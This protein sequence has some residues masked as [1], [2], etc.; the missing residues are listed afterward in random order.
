MQHAHRAAARGGRRRTW[1]AEGA[2]C[3]GRSPPASPPSAAGQEPLEA[4]QWDL[5]RD[6]RGQGA[7]EVAGQ[8]QGDGRRDRHRR[9]RHAPRPRAELRPSARRSTVSAGKPDTTDGRVARRARR[10]T[11]TARTWPVRSRRR[12]N[13]VGV[14]GVAP[15]VKVAG[16]K[17]S[18]TAGYF[19]TE[20]V[21]CGFVCA[22]DARRGDHE[23]QL[24][25]RPL[26]LTTARTTR[27]R[28]RS[29]TRS[30][31]RAVRGE[32][33]HGQ[34]RGGRQ[35]QLRPGGRRDHRPVLAERRH[36]SERVVD[37]SKCL[38]I[39]TQLPGVV[40]VAATGAKGIKSS[41]S[42]HGLGFIDVA[43]PGGDSTTYQKPRRPRRTAGSWARCPAASGATWPVRR[44]RAR[45]WR[46]SPR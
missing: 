34:R 5:A 1:G 14:P 30:R 7:R 32:E 17:V 38:D 18:T 4:E 35:R 43:A 31:G 25:R 12:S 10:R 33:G 41:F 19:Y 23:Q 29:W 16:I 22:A 26:V 46:P 44:W 15:G 45:T 8:P 42:N 39:P 20:A 37:P 28:R 9:R 40:T 2:Q 36:A 6:R 3:D 21:V 11:R 13:G 27:T 24:L